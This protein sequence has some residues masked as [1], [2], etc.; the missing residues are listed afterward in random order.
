MFGNILLLKNMLLLRKAG[1]RMLSVIF[2]TKA[3]VD[4][5]I[6]EQQQ[7]LGL[8]SW[9]NSSLLQPK[10]GILPYIVIYKKVDDRGG[11]FINA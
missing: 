1:P 10:A 9:A 2:L 4:E 3:S 11:A 7:T 6:P 5:A 8:L